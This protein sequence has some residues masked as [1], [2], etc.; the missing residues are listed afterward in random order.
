M[1]SV[2]EKLAA[3]R[4]EMFS[5][6]LCASDGEKSYSGDEK[7]GLRILKCAAYREKRHRR[8]FVLFAR[9]FSARVRMSNRQT[10][11]YMDRGRWLGGVNWWVGVHTKNGGSLGQPVGHNHMQ[12]A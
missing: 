11:M 12:E 9:D 7:F 3:Y 5:V 10:D 2:E 4:R 6:Y 8:R 1:A